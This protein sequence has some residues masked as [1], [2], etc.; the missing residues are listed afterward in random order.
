[1]EKQNTF[2]DESDEVIRCCICKKQIVYPEKWYKVDKYYCEDC[3]E[4]LVQSLQISEK[5]ILDA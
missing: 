3:Y 1:M 2:T 4:D 5:K